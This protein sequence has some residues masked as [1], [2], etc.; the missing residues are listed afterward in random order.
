MS[1]GSL[2]HRLTQDMD[3]IF[4]FENVRQALLVFR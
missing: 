2:A 4:S 1:E 3:Q